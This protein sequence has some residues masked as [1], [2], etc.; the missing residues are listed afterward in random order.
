MS[1]SEYPIWAAVTPLAL[2]AALH[3]LLESLD[4]SYSCAP[5]RLRRVPRQ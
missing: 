5:T 3:S 4:S 2:L 1:L